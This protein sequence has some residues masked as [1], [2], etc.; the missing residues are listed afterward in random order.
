MNTLP[1]FEELRITLSDAHQALGVPI[2]NEWSF[3]FAQHMRTSGVEY[4]PNE[5]ATLLREAD[6]AWN[7]EGE[8]HAWEWY[9]AAHIAHELG[10]L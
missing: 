7:A 5:L 3:N 9:V 1:T 6:T 4:D 2:G 10:K 8:Q